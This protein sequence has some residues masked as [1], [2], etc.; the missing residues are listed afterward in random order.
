N[1]SE[2]IPEYVNLEEKDT[3]T[4]N[5]KNKIVE[6]KNLMNIDNDENFDTT[7]IIPDNYENFDTTT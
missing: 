5:T 7:T 3:C 6:V 4:A 2:A 1:T